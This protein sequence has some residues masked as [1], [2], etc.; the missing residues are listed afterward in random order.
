MNSEKKN[1]SLASQKKWRLTGMLR[2]QQL[3]LAASL[4]FFENKLLLEVPIFG[5]DV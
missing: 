2:L 3:Y 1:I 4:S 5:L